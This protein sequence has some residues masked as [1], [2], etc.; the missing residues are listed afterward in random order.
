MEIIFV[1]LVALAVLTFFSTRRQRKELQKT[2]QLQASLAVGDEVMT[3]SGMYGTV[4]G[5]TDTTVDLEVAYEVVTT[6][7]RAVVRE[8]VTTDATDATDQDGVEDEHGGASAVTATSPVSTV[9]DAG[10]NTTRVE[11]DGPTPRLSKD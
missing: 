3:T 10:A 5:L 11:A 8:R 4:V 7:N 2:Q 6:W 1:A 9:D